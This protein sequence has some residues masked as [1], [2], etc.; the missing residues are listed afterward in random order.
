MFVAKPEEFTECFLGPDG[1]KNNLAEFWDNVEALKDPRLHDHPMCQHTNWKQR[2]I[3]SCLHG[4]GVPVLVV[5]R[6]NAESMESIA[7]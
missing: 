1:N 3:P 4:D 2:A 7:W 5:G 6:A